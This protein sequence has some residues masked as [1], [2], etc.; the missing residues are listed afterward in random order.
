MPEAEQVVSLPV[1]REVPQR[2]AAVGGAVEG[3]RRSVG[4]LD[5]DEVRHARPPRVRGPGLRNAVPR[6]V[7]RDGAEPA[8]AGRWLTRERFLSAAACCF[9]YV[10]SFFASLPVFL[11]QHRGALF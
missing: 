1:P 2:A 9:S 4:S 8:M 10:A 3:G 6:A 5:P 11:T 7:V